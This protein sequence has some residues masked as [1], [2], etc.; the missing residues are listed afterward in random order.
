MAKER[1]CFKQ[2]G[3]VGRGMKSL[4]TG[5]YRKMCS[6]VGGED[7]ASM[8]ATK[9][10]EKYDDH[11]PANM[12]SVSDI[13]LAMMQMKSPNTK[14]LE[15]LHKVLVWPIL[16]CDSVPKNI[17]VDPSMKR[18]VWDVL[19]C[20]DDLPYYSY[21]EQFVN[22]LYKDKVLETKSLLDSGKLCQVSINMKSFRNE[23]KEVKHGVALSTRLLETKVFCQIDSC[24]F[25][26]SSFE[27]ILATVFSHLCFYGIENAVRGFVVDSSHGAEVCNKIEEILPKTVAFPCQSYALRSLLNTIIKNDIR[28]QETLQEC[29]RLYELAKQ[30]GMCT[31][32]MAQ[33]VS[34][35]VDL[36]RGTEAK[37]VSKVQYCPYL[38]IIESLQQD[39]RNHRSTKQRNTELGVSE[40][41]FWSQLLSYSKLLEPLL[42]SLTTLE[43]DG[44]SLGQMH[45]I[46]HCITRNA[47]LWC[48]LMENQKH[49]EPYSS[50]CSSMNTVR[51]LVQ[52]YKDKYYHPAFT[53]GYLMDLRLWNSSNGISRPNVSNLSYSEIEDARK[54]ASKLSASPRSVNDELTKILQ[55]GIMSSQLG[56]FSD[57]NT[58]IM[59]GCIVQKDCNEVQ[60]RNLMNIWSPYSSHGPNVVGGLFPAI[61]ELA[62]SIFVMRAT[63]EKSPSIPSVMKWLYKLK[64]DGIQDETR[65]RMA[66]IALSHR[67]HEANS[68][69]RQS[70]GTFL[71]YFNLDQNQIEKA[72]R[73]VKRSKAAQGAQKNIGTPTAFMANHDCHTPKRP[74][75]VQPE[76]DLNSDPSH[77]TPSHSPLLQLTDQTNNIITKDWTSNRGFQENQSGLYQSIIRVRN[78]IKDG[79]KDSRERL[80]QKSLIDDFGA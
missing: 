79:S 27:N 59:C 23:K 48:E 40:E 29:C 76:F 6:V 26:N 61:G 43:T 39:I 71:S 69:S 62:P 10:L 14:K 58:K 55:Y 54:L 20:H 74:V 68:I 52:G 36:I 34:S 5:K 75:L 8:Q 11:G 2:R 70:A 64:D 65:R 15:I 28:L 33:E 19:G 13:L 38:L 7:Q 44:A 1:K 16:H 42:H 17:L 9:S 72:W 30:W 80:V 77:V 60:I 12:E 18:F 78:A 50:Q 73:A 37:M 32:E 3:L 21:L 46:W 35:W 45:L 56:S 47:D 49:S 22:T 66:H 51:Q 63:C 53:L 31:N 57:V 24:T 41:Q 25:S 4:T 67:I